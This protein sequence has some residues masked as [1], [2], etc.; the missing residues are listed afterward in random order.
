MTTNIPYNNS[1]TVK[2]KRE[3]LRNDTYLARA[4]NELGA[5]LGGRFQHLARGQ[6]HVVGTA[7]N[8]WPQMPANN[9]WSSNVVPNEEPLGVDV[10]AVPD[11]TTVDGAP[12]SSS[13]VERSAAPPKT[14][15]ETVMDR[16]VGFKRRI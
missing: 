10:S 16:I 13:A 12:R 8:P 9:P 3:A 7:P 4:Q 11:M 6:Q 1:A 2:E 14:E 5:E 15:T